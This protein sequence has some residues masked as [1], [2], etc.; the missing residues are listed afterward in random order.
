MMWVQYWEWQIVKVVDPVKEPNIPPIAIAVWS[1]LQ[2][3][4]V[5]LVYTDLMSCDT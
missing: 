2:L 4:L 1:V 3:P 5:F